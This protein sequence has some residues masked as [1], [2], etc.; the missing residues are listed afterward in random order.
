MSNN[1]LF[2]HVQKVFD[3][4]LLSGKFF[5]FFPDEALDDSKDFLEHDGDV[6]E[7]VELIVEFF[8]EVV[9]GVGVGDQRGFFV[10]FSKEKSGLFF[11]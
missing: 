5:E 6:V 10:I 8:L 2:G 3:V 9:K 1:L 11:Y 7:I 4:W